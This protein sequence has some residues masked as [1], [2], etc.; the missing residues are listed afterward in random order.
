MF[1]DTIAAIA[2]PIGEGGLAVVR[3]SGANALTIAD[4]IFQPTG[5]NSVKPSAAD[6]HTIHFGKI[7]RPL[8][9]LGG[10]KVAKPG[11][12]QIID[13]VLLA[14]LRAPRTFT[15][16]DTIEI[17]CHGGIL[18]AKLVLDTILANGARLA[19]PGE[20]TKR[21]FLNGRIDLAQA[22][23]VADLIHSR[24]ELA[25]AAANEQ[26]AG[27]LSQRINRLRDDLMHTLA[28]IEAHIDFPDEDIA[29]DTKD[30]L[31]ERLQNGVSFMDELLRTANEGQ[32]LRRGI[33]AAII[34]RPN[35]GK[36]SLL[37]QLLGHDRAIVSPIAGTTRDTIEE[38]A[39]IRGLPVVF[40]DTAGLREARDE[41]E[42]EGIRRSRDSL[43][44]ADLILHVLDASENLTREDEHFLAEFS[45]KKRILVLNK[46]D[47]PKKLNLNSF[48]PPS[49]G[50]KVGM[51]GD[52]K[53]ELLTP[54]LSSF[55]EER[56]N[57]LCV[58]EISCATEQGIEQLK[59]AIKNLIWSGEINAE[60]LQVAIN[61]RHQDAL[62]RARAAA[63]Q[64]MDALRENATLELVAMDLR[65][66]ANAVGEIV[67][68]TTTEDLL[69][70]IFSAFCIGK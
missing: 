13:E 33:R 41:I 66:A 70:S 67:G 55:G 24:T 64:A 17:S 37:N 15:R 36:S 19:E 49:S 30:K 56:E 60:N 46:S 27:K 20:F 58:V 11:E 61:S 50:E 3:I 28:H 42:V 62:N 69:D 29:P 44:K 54:T 21:A 52:S 32:I 47:L 63:Q 40:I 7:V 45:G 59:D 34:G 35:A 6:S 43:Q 4:K 22:E 38:T 68:K 65:I 31:L 25:L 18:P 26:L 1:D 9:P 53:N 12:G 51:R 23:A 10:E 14:V 2:T 39:N 8:T 5:K 48:S 16:E 57:S